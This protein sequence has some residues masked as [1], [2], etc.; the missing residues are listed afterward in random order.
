MWVTIN[1]LI[2]KTKQAAIKVLLS[3]GIQ[4]EERRGK[5][6]SQTAIRKNKNKQ[7]SFCGLYRT[8]L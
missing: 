8:Q 2:S 3:S 6:E 5:K 7:I 1:G 4:A